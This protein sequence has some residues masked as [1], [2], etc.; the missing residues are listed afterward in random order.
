MTAG[1]PAGASP[2][3]PVTSLGVVVRRS[4]QAGNAVRRICEAAARAGVRLEIEPHALPAATG[5]VQ[6]YQPGSEVDAVLAVGGD[7]TFLRAAR[8]LVGREVPLLGVNLGHL[9]FLTSAG[10]A[11][12]EGCVERLAAGA[13]HTEARFTLAASLLDDDGLEHVALND[14]VLH[15]DGVARVVRLNLRVGPPGEEEDIGGFSGD[16]IVV[17]TPTG[18]TAYNLSAGGPIVM[19]SME[20]LLIT[21]ICPHTLTVRPLLVSAGTSVVIRSVEPHPSL[22]LT[23]DG[24]EATRVP[25][26]GGIRVSRGR[27]VVRIVRF[28]GRTFFRTLR[29]KLR[30]AARPGG[31][32]DEE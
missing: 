23:M 1:V 28:P 26:L 22:V 20:A 7:G 31:D 30:W 3:T 29:R 6:P 21:A 12:L 9:G 13:F 8:A 25:S 19:P 16:G 10:E 14:A 11:E 24:Q 27:D 32:L 17:A 2:G 5:D 4:V 18:S 15:T